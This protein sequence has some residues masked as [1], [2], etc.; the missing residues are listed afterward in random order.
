MVR[1][2]QNTPKMQDTAKAELAYFKSLIGALYVCM[3]NNLELC[4]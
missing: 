3:P 2:P 4:R 1:L